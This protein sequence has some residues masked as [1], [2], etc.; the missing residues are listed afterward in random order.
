MKKV[1]KRPSVVSSETDVTFNR[2]FI[3]AVKAERC[4]YDFKLPAYAS[5][6]AQNKAWDRLSEQF[7]ESGS[8]TNNMMIWYSK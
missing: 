4:L 3:A 7:Q 1:H 6:D 8:W 2:E 5:K